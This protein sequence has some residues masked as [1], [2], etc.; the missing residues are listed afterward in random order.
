MKNLA[1]KATSATAKAV[2]AA[3]SAAS[4]VVKS[5]VSAA[6]NTAVKVAAKTKS[7]KTSSSNNKN[8]FIPSTVG[9]ALGNPFMPNLLK[10]GN[11][12]LSTFNDAY[13]NRMIHLCTTGNR[14]QKDS[15][16]PVKG[17]KS[18]PGLMQVNVP[19]GKVISYNNASLLS[20]LHAA[21][22]TVK[23]D[24]ANLGSNIKEIVTISPAAAKGLALAG[25]VGGALAVGIGIGAYGVT[26]P[27]V[28]KVLLMAQ[29]QSPEMAEALSLAANIGYK[30]YTGQITQE[31]SGDK[32]KENDKTNEKGDSKGKEKVENPTKGE[33]DVW[34]DL[35]NVKGQDRKTSGQG[36]EKQ[37]YEWDHTHNDIEVYDKN[38]NH[39]GSMDPTTGEM[40][41][42]PVPGRDINLR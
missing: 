12:I 41:K 19:G 24:I 10:Q 31:A 17:L 9:G 33:S 2:Q 16:S 29:G 25:T 5:T 30:Y 6:A 21:W 3:K 32:T 37:Y 36:K 35:D 18:S 34:K 42:P 26:R 4:A 20:D 38:G 7:P 14:V 11:N 40:Y 13:T 28:G 23:G 1:K 27:E 22:N 8:T 39:L 15:V